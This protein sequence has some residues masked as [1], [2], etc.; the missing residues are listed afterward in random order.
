M[1][2]FLSSSDDK[3]ATFFMVVLKVSGCC[4]NKLSSSSNDV[5]RMRVSNDD[6]LL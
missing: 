1:V 2:R 6:L 4:W 5:S 3:A